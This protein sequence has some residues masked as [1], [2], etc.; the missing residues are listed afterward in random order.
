MQPLD[1]ILLLKLLKV[2]TRV[3]KVPDNYDVYVL[4]LTNTQLNSYKKLRTM[5]K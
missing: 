4:V 2:R 1:Q 3:G 5:L